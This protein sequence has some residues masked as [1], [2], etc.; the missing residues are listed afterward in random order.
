M[1][2]T[3]FTLL[4]I[5]ASPVVSFS[6][7][8]DAQQ[9]QLEILI[10][11]K[12]KELANPSNSIEQKTESLRVVRKALTSAAHQMTQIPRFRIDRDL[13]FN[14]LPSIIELMKPDVD[15]DAYVVCT[16]LQSACPRPNKELWRSWLGNHTSPDSVQWMWPT[17]PG[18]E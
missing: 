13:A 9:M 3:L 6:E 12:F 4:F 8:G 5:C 7:E 1:N 14:A 17:I 11:N 2:N 10:A 15:C 16:L 18:Q